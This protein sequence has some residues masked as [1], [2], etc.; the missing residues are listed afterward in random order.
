MSF[1]GNHNLLWIGSNFY[2]GLVLIAALT[3][4]TG[5]G[6]KAVR[7]GAG[8]DNPQLDELA[9]SVKLD[10]ADIE[11]LV[12]QNIKALSK[13]AVWNNTIERAETPPV[14]AIWSI[15]NATS[16]HIEDQMTALLS[17]IETYLVNSGDVRVVSRERQQKLVNELRLRQSD[18]YDP[19]TIGKFGRQLGAQYFVTGKITSVEER[20]QKTRRVQYSLMLQVLEVETG[21][22][23]FQNEASRSK[24]VKR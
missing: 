9:L 8:T 20:L 12:S 6:P 22:I 10:R 23:K 16:Q 11:Y 4:L 17:S 5:C 1:K 19:Q 14:V 18:I 21:L 7:G 2:L 13:S 24:A 15:Q 3:I